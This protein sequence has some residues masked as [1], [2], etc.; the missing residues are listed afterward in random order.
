MHPMSSAVQCI[1]VQYS[2]LSL[3]NFAYEITKEY[4]T[5]GREK[6]YDGHEAEHC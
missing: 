4:N 5:E 6:E 2:A 1:A 3:N